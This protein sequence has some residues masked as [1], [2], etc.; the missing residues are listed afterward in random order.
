MAGLQK[1]VV[2]KPTS[3]LSGNQMMAMPLDGTVQ[4]LVGM[5]VSTIAMPRPLYNSNHDFVMV[6]GIGY[7]VKTDYNSNTCAMYATG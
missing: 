7:R 6:A 3:K 2:L 4:P 5:G 1:V